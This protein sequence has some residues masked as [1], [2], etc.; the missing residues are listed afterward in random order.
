M[1][2]ELPEEALRLRL[3]EALGRELLGESTHELHRA[4]TRALLGGKRLRPM[5]TCLW[6]Q[7][8]GAHE[9]DLI[10][11]GLAVG[12]AYLRPGARRPPCRRR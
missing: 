5:L 12:G 7:R 10:Q 6:G 2:D 1:K 8:Y 4:M 11:A 3:S 9:D